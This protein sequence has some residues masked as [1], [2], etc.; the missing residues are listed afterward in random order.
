M[1]RGSN[2]GSPREALV[3]EPYAS[4]DARVVMAMAAIE[5][6]PLEPEAEV[7]RGHALLWVARRA[8]GAP[9]EGYLLAWRVADEM[10]ILHLVVHPTARRRG[11][12]GALLDRLLTEGR[13]QGVCAVHLEVR[14]SN[15]PAL[16]LYRSR[17]FREEGRRRAYY[18][19][20]EDALILSAPLSASDSDARV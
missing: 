5:H 16:E 20:G 7:R 18:G 3:V 6:L 1:N 8:R 2:A 10:E 12:G 11:L 15:Q 19:D 4:H 13:A 9:A 17:G 14:V